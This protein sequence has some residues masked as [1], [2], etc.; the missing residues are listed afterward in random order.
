[1][2]LRGID[3]IAIQTYC[4]M[5]QRKVLNNNKQANLRRTYNNFK[6]MHPTQEQLSI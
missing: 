5:K 3:K 6:H 1:M 4:N 2:I